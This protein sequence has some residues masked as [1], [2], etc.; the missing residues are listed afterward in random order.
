MVAFIGQHR[1][2][3][4]EIAQ[5]VDVKKVQTLQLLT[6]MCFFTGGILCV[7]YLFNRFIVG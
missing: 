7:V 4:L 3:A 5:N 2:K 1:L 6:M